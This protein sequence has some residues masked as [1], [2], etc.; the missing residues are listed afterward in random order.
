[1]KRWWTISMTSNDLLFIRSPDKQ[2]H[3]QSLLHC[4][5]LSTLSYCCNE[6]AFNLLHSLIPLISFL[7]FFYMN[8]SAFDLLH[9]FCCAVLVSSV[10]QLCFCHIYAAALVIII[11]L[12]YS[13][14]H[15]LW[16]ISINSIFSDF[17]LQSHFGQYVTLIYNN[18]T[19]PLYFYLKYSLVTSQLYLVVKR[20]FFPCTDHKK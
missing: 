20:I 17:S 3:L 12:L 19:T 14:G 11:G 18:I 15:L 7:L 9:S 6:L 8:E 4:N 13:I 2:K 1:M 16:K 5:V 10:R